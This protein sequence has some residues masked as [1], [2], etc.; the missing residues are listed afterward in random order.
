MAARRDTTGT[1][2]KEWDSGARQ[3][4]MSNI[5]VLEIVMNR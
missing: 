3:V 2:G 4:H 1:P 5:P